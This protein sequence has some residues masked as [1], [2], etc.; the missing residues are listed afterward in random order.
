MRIAWLRD[1]P[2]HIDALAA[3]H[4]QAFGALLPDW[5]VEQGIAELRSQLDGQPIP[6]TLLALDA[7]GDWLGSVS[8]LHEDHERI[9]Q[10]SP[11]LAS[12]YVRRE[13]RGRGVGAA[14]VARCVAEA[15]A[16]GVTRLYLYCTM[17]LAG[18][19]RALGWRE[20]DRV[21]FGPLHLVVMAVDCRT[22]A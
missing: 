21:S 13:A 5:T 14:L 1:H 8:L 12:P 22:P 18:Y 17:P 16:A 19:Y 4:V 6:A 15:S 7:G 10:Y 2:Q 9:R 3:A 11:C 20:H